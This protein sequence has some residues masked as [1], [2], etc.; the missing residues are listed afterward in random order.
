VIFAALISVQGPHS[1]WYSISE[2]L[3]IQTID[4]SFSCIP[5]YIDI[6][7]DQSM[8]KYV[9]PDTAFAT[10]K[11]KPDDLVIISGDFLRT[12][13]WPMS[14]RQE[15]LLALIALSESFYAEFGA[16]LDVVSGYRS[17]ERQASIAA[18][19]SP[20]VCARP[21]HSEHQWWLAIDLF[22][23]SNAEK[24]LADNNRRLYYTRLLEHAHEYGW[25]NSY[26]KGI[27]TDGYHAEPR[28]R[29]YLGVELAAYLHKKW[30]TFAEC[31][32]SDG[33]ILEE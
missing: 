2:S 28:H 21:G 25:H 13:R 7:D 17:Y 31:V 6:L 3:D 9:W 30:M 12:S 24:F 8:S 29:R 23:F 5:A 33:W 1:R 16:K 10:I 32:L 26:Q 22:D 19:C 14:I 11:Y 27:D 4:N 20:S 18:W 15:A